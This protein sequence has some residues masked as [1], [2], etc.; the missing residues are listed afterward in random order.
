[1]YPWLQADWQRLVQRAQDHRLPHA[2]LIAGPQGLGKL[3]LAEH[4]ARYLLC[5][6]PRGDQPCG[7]CRGCKLLAA[8]SHPDYQR[9]AP[10]EPG[11]A[12]K[13][14][15]VRQFA[16][17]TALTPQYGGYK[18]AIIEPAE[19]LN[20]NAA[21]SLLKTLEEP[22]GPT[23]MLL[24]SATPHRL[25][26]TIRSRCQ[27]LP[28]TAPAP[29]V[30]LAWLAQQG[31]DAG[32]AGHLL[33]LAEGAPLRALALAGQD[34]VA[35]REQ[36]LAELEGLAAGHSDPV[37]V[38]AEWQAHA[39][40]TPLYWFRQWIMDMIRI[41]SAA[42]PPRLSNPDSQARLHKLVQTLDLMKL[43]R[44]L[45]GLNEALRLVSTSQVNPQLLT[46]EQLIRWTA[47]QR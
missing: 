24:V 34:L 5:D 22:A 41:K 14:D 38:A 21:N 18:L 23:I 25:P 30:A 36:F 45:D 7:E 31:L 37:A 2:L 43:Y 11:K 40:S 33:A 27:L 17:F 42:A 10:E 28:V 19:Q 47:C 39:E 3:A 9:L 1:M 32:Q 29:S 12:I 26:A 6:A 8:G 15:Q 35:L 44:L 20:R 46:E 4:F 16:D 13:V